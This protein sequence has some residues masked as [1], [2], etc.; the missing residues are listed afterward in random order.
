MPWAD[1]AGLSA[2]YLTES[3][4]LLNGWLYDRTDPYGGGVPQDRFDK[5]ANVAQTAKCPVF[6]DGIWINSWPMEMDVPPSPADLYNGNNV[7][8]LTPGGGGMGRVLIARHGG[9]P[10]AKAPTN[11]P[12]NSRLPGAINIGMFDGHVELVPLQNLWLYYWHLNWQP[13]SNPWTR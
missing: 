10:P 6:A 3:S 12:K 1:N 7:Q 2:E 13:R 4:Y 5:E 11:V 9:A 8:N